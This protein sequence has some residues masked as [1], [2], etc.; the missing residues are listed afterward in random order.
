MRSCRAERQQLIWVWELRGWAFASRITKFIIWV[1]VIRYCY[2][3]IHFQP[4]H[5]ENDKIK[6]QHAK[7]YYYYY[8]FIQNST[9]LIWAFRVSDEQQKRIILPIKQHVWTQHLPC[10]Q[11]EPWDGWTGLHPV[12]IDTDIT[13]MLFV[14]AY[15][16][17]AARWNRLF[18]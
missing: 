3:L 8:Y 17:G 4:S 9:R 16:K 2:D 13:F 10:G 7:H 18:S 1:N 11:M 15:F 12:D 6:G 5:N 14:S